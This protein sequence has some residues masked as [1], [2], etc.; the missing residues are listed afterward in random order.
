M[1]RKFLDKSKVTQDKFPEIKSP[2]DLKTGTGGKPRLLFVEDD[3]TTR[4][5]CGGAFGAI[6]FEVGLASNG[7]EGFSLFEMGKYAVIV[8]DLNMPKMSGRVL[9]HKIKQV[10][11]NQKIF[12]YSGESP[13]EE[14]KQ[15]IGADMVFC[16][17]TYS[18]LKGALTDLRA[19][20][21]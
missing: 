11:P 15:S 12:V 10:D 16:P 17:E 6:G 7:E 3:E 20:T 13:T 5:V 9:I 1:K 19:N 8:T 4:R 18:E 2:D 14:Q 21:N